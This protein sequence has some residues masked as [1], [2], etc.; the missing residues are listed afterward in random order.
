[1]YSN[2][3]FSLTILEYKKSIALPLFFQPIDMHDNN[4]DNNNFYS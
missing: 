1:M 3:K 2:V 4:D